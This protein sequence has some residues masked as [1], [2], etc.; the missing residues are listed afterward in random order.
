MIF[1]PTPQ[2]EKKRLNALHELNILDS[3]CEPQFDSI[4]K[5]VAE[6][7]N[8]SMSFIAFIDN[9]RQW[10]KST[11]GT[12]IK[13]LPRIRS[14]CGH[15]INEVNTNNSK[16]RIYQ[17]YDTK[18]D[19]RFFD[20]PLVTGKPWVRSYIGYVLQ[21]DTSNMNIGTMCVLDTKPR[22]YTHLE[23]EF[24]ISIGR[25]TEALINSYS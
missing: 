11:Y 20:N 15:T 19:I 10:F 5:R 16:D 2:C 4:T 18:N 22:L 8:T 7:L 6:E 13:E 14:I 25:S 9:D 17:I 21:E 1:A 24:L 12:N 23:K 3:P